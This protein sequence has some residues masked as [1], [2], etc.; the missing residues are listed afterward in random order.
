[1]L[2]LPF[3][4]PPPYAPVDEDYHPRPN[5][6]YSLSKVLGEKMAAQFCRW[7]PS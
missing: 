1:M 3:D 5:S 6:S 4:E 2:G 7:D